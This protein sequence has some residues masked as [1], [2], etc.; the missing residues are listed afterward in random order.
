M[1]EVINI[2]NF[3]GGV[4]KTTTS[5]MLS[6]LFSQMNKRVLFVDF[7]PQGN[8]TDLLYYKTFQ[9]DAPK[10]SIFSA[11]KEED[12]SSAVHKLTDTLDIIPAEKDLRNFPRLLD[13]RFGNDYKLYAFLLDALLRPLKPNYDYIFIDVPPT[14]SDF[15]DNAIVASDHIAI[16]MQTQEFSLGAAEEFI[17]YINELVETFDIDI[18]LVAA[19]PVLMKDGAKTD[20]FILQEAS[21]LFGDKMTTNPIKIRERVKMW[22]ITGIKNEDMHDKSVLNMYEKL[23]NEIIGRI[24][25]K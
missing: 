17:P 20:E 14:I 1:T 13:V 4:G 12:L 6:L 2:A 3:K 18:N 15:T 19:I 25:T 11:M 24:E 9:Q 5:V 21:K 8:G 22:G 16:V 23:A 10:K 7:D